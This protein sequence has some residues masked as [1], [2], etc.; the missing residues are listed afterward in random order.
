MAARGGTCAV[1]L[2]E[3]TARWQHWISIGSC[4][5]YLINVNIQDGGRRMR[6]RAKSEPKITF[7]HYYN[8]PT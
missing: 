2:K 4:I 1:V 5:R 3:L 6:S 8:G 7:Y